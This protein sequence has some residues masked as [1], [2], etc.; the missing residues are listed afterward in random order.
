MPLHGVPLPNLLT[1][2]GQPVALPPRRLKLSALPLG[3]VHSWV[4]SSAHTSDA[5]NDSTTSQHLLDLGADTGE[6]FQPC[7]GLGL[8]RLES[9]MGPPRHAGRVSSMEPADSTSKPAT[10]FGRL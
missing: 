5:R 10:F 9:P 8:G 3:C 6:G 2:Q 7:D 4:V 1:Q